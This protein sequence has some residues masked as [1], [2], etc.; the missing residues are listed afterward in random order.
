M[1]LQGEARTLQRT[2]PRG[3]QVELQGGSLR[4]RLA[5]TPD[6][7]RRGTARESRRRMALL[8]S[9]SGSAS[10][11]CGEKLC[12]LKPSARRAPLAQPQEAKTVCC[13]ARVEGPC[14]EVRGVREAEA[15]QKCFHRARSPPGDAVRLIVPR[16]KGESVRATGTCRAEPGASAVARGARTPARRRPSRSPRLVCARGRCGASGLRR[17]AGASRGHS[18]RRW[19]N[20][21]HEDDRSGKDAVG[22]RRRISSQ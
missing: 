22:T 21:P 2:R 5:R 6:T 4:S 14:G 7:G 15:A 9:A 10:G 19:R 8:A 1:S 18:S 17:D 20:C 12:G 3:K 13:A 11:L 16:R